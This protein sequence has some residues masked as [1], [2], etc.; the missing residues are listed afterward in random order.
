MA[1]ENPNP[2]RL[3]AAAHYGDVDTVR[4]L[5]HNAEDVNSVNNKGNTALVSALIG[6]GKRKIKEVIVNLL[7]DYGANVNAVNDDGDSV[8]HVLVKATFHKKIPSKTIEKL[9][10]HGAD[11]T[12]VNKNNHNPCQLAFH[13]NNSKLG[14]LLLFYEKPD[15]LSDK[16]SYSRSP[17]G[18]GSYINTFTTSI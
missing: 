17:S 5:L 2:F 12:I 15:Y 9:I 14:T 8:L 13:V 3:H 4:A 6:K 7:L 1:I 18:S 16:P 10:I 11:R